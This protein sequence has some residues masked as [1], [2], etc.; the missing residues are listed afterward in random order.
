MIYKPKDVP[1]QV[2]EFKV[3]D[4]I[5]PS[6]EVQNTTGEKQLYKG[7]KYSSDFVSRTYESDS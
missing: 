2:F 5:Q 6:E 4:M 3:E 7:E 1:E